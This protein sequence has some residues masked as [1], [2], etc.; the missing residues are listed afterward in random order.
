MSPMVRFGTVACVLFAS[1]I[2]VGC[3]SADIGSD[4][5]A[6]SEQNAAKEN[7]PSVPPSTQSTPLPN[8]DP[9]TSLPDDGPP[10]PPAVT[11]AALLA[12]L[13]ACKKLSTA[14]YAKDSGG[15][16]NIDV[17][18]LKNAVWWQGDMDIDCDGKSSA[19]CNKS[20]DA[21]Y[22]AQ[23]A[24]TDSKGAYLDAA[25]LP[26]VVVPGVSTRWS[27]KTAGIAMGTVAV[28]IYNGNIAYGIVGDIGPTSIVGEA[29][30][31][32]A[33]S[34]G[35]N[36]NP[37]TGGV[38]SGVTY[39]FFTGPTGKVNKNEDHAEAVSVGQK[40]AAQFLSEN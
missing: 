24:T 18:G 33:K 17:C 7:D 27:Y 35:I 23:T 19:V 8:T 13:G 20:T 39:I 32:M 36:P 26:F 28:V 16:A 21:S 37:S 38:S 29:S 5:D 30:Y 25:T 11:A 10:K 40:R 31:A 1:S 4:P 15:T 2:V 6:E 34:L 14:P 9:T 12:K 3:S 22:Q